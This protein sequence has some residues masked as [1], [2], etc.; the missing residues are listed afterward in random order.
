[1]FNHSTFY[2]TLLLALSTALFAAGCTQNEAAEPESD[3]AEPASWTTFVTPEELHARLDDENL[4][5]VDA[6]PAEQYEEGHIPGAINLP[7]SDWRTPSA[8]PGE[9]QSKY[10]FRKADNSVDTER[11]E[12]FLGEAGI[13]SDSDVVVYGD[14]AGNKTGT[15]PVMILKGL[16][17]ESA[18]FLDGVGLEE[19]KEAGYEVST[20]SNELPPAT[21]EAS[22]DSNFIWN[23]DDVL[24][25]I[26]RENV[27]IVDTRS[28]EEYTGENPRD[29][30]RAGH[31]PGA[32]RVNYSDLM[33]W[34]ER[35]TLPP[36]E[37]QRVLNEKGL[38]DKEETT[39]V[40][41][42]QTSTR[43]SENY[44]VMKELGYENVAVYDAS[45]F[46][47]GNRDDTPI[48]TGTD[49]ADQPLTTA[50]H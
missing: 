1:M 40:L 28:I 5:I 19:W 2:S 47:Y 43:V 41:H 36:S 32:V 29:N 31:I 39:Y 7:G 17:H 34:E 15:V 9:G 46:E 21:F 38:I 37:A 18:Y 23:L 22:L 20:E 42:C 35:K 30:K 8:E 16:G 50:S 25:G 13:G 3:A 12:R 11:Y 10:L 44:L 6:R 26:D 49:E 33:D 4:V 45:W 48:V 24:E 14:F 27:V